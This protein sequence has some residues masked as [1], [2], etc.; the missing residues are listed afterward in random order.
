MDSQCCA[1]KK[2]RGS[3]WGQEA[4]VIKTGC[5]SVCV[6]LCDVL[7]QLSVLLFIRF[8]VINSWHSVSPPT[9]K[10]KEVLICLLLVLLINTEEYVFSFVNHALRGKG[11]L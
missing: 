6:C 8:W 7:H 1:L 3:G 5:D 2:A 4:D 10:K 9:K 11:R